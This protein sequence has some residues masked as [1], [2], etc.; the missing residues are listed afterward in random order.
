MVDINEAWESFCEGN[1]EPCSSPVYSHSSLQSSLD[2]PNSTELYIS[3]KTKLSYLNTDIDLID[4]FWKI[5][6]IPYHIPVE[7]VIKKEMKFN[8]STSE[9]LN[10]MKTLIPQDTYVD[11]HIITHIEN[12]KGR[13]KFKDIRKVSIG[14]SKKDMISTRGKKKGAFYNCFVLI[15][16]IIH[17]D[18]FKEIHVKIF[19]T[20]KLKIPGIQND[21]TLNKTLNLLVKILYPIL[22]DRNTP[23]CFIPDKT[24]TVLINS[25]FNCGYHINR[26]KL[27]EILKNKY[28]L[29]CAYDP[30]SYPG[31]HSEFY[32]KTGCID[33]NGQQPNAKE[34]QQYKIKQLHFKVFRTGSIL[35]LGKC[36]ESIVYEI[37][38][39]L[40]GLFKTEYTQVGGE[41]V[42]LIAKEEN[43]KKTRKTRKRLIITA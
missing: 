11:E 28:R 39:F 9:E 18:R 35:I 13:I 1:Y 33:Q 19:N 8:S 10:S 15:L 4:T 32:Y 30:C 23:L 7:G 43:N 42:K 3:T 6:L 36:S 26:Q 21:M 31:I 17:E 16:R 25:N 20:G 14:I 41:H 40:C 34:L 24:E 12:P 29:N 2:I 37:Y 22:P 38:E 27:Y 5:P